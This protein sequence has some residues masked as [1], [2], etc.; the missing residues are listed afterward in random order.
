MADKEKG[1]M[2]DKGFKRLVKGSRA[3]GL[4]FNGEYSTLELFGD[5]TQLTTIGFNY[6]G[7]ERGFFGT[8]IYNWDKVIQ[9]NMGALLSIIRNGDRLVFSCRTN[10]STNLTNAGLYNDELLVDIYR[11]DRRIVSQM[12]LE[13]SICASNSARAIKI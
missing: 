2:V 9:G 4:R 1:I 13:H 7:K 12:I 5:G 11:K 6:Q 10:N 8:S 3:V